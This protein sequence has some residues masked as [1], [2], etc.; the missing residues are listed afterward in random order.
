VLQL[1]HLSHHVLV[2]AEIVAEID[3]NGQSHF[4]N[5]TIIASIEAG[6]KT[7]LVLMM[8]TAHPNSCCVTVIF[9]YMVSHK[10]L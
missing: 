2:T 1:S 3:K 4:G 5:H 8:P 9:V 10:I 6:I 7:W